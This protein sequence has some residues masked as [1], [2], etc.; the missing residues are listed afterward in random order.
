[1]G[2]FKSIVLGL[3][4]GLLIGLWFGVNLGKGRDF[5]ANPFVGKDIAGDLMESS[6]EMLE[7]SGKA[8]KNMNKD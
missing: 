7:K 8:L 5:Y 6:G 3:V 2:T 1:M 4:I